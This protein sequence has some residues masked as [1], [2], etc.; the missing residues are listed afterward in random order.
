MR[1]DELL[2]AIADSRRIEILVILLR[3]PMTQARL[4]DALSTREER[5][6]NPGT[7]SAAIQPLLRAGLIHRDR[8]RGPLF[9]PHAAHVRNLL[10]TAARL[11]ITINREEDLRTGLGTSE[12]RRLLGEADVQPIRD[13]I[14]FEARDVPDA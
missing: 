1:M 10:Q 13:F 8:P 11:V 7:V 14:P 6:L 12:L 9:V 3:E 2:R 4:A 5:R